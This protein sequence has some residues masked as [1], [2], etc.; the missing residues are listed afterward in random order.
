M[1]AMAQLKIKPVIGCIGGHRSY[2]LTRQQLIIRL[3]RHASQSR[4]NHIVA[5]GYLQDQ[6]LSALMVRPGIKNLAVSG[7]NDLG[8]GLGCIGK[9]GIGAV[10]G[11]HHRA[12]HRFQQGILSP[13]RPENL[14]FPP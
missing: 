13:D 2:R 7:G 4:Q 8:A 14:N 6:H 3:N 12:D 10:G 1:A 9:P 11:S 5:G